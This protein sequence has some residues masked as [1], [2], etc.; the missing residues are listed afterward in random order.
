MGSFIKN[1]DES[2]PLYEL[3]NEAESLLIA[4]SRKRSPGWC[5]EKFL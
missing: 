3:S 4:L 5:S 1:S 2:M